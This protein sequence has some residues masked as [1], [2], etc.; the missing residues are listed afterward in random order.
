MDFLNGL[1]FREIT[2]DESICELADELIDKCSK[3]I[4]RYPGL[5]FPASRSPY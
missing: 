4:G 5:T 1:A 3:S 2:L